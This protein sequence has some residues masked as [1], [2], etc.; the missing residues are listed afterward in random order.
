MIEDGITDSLIM[1]SDFS[2]QEASFESDQPIFI[3]MIVDNTQSK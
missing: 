2:K 1:G 3:N